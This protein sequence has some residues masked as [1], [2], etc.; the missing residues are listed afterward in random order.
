MS[1][2][3]DQCLNLKKQEDCGGDGNRSSS[4]FRFYLSLA[5]VSRCLHIFTK[6]N[7]I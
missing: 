4:R 7:L 3:E 1:F 5:V 2:L 6:K